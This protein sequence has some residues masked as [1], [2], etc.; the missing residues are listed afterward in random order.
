[1]L[2]EHHDYGDFIAAISNDDKRAAILKVLNQIFESPEFA[3]ELA[4]ELFDSLNDPD[5][6]NTHPRMRQLL[7]ALEL[8]LFEEKEHAQSGKAGGGKRPY[9]FPSLRLGRQK[10]KKSDELLQLSERFTRLSYKCT[11]HV[12]LREFGMFTD[13]QT[14]AAVVATRTKLEDCFRI[15]GSVLKDKISDEQI[16]EWYHQLRVRKLADVKSEVSALLKVD[17]DQIGD[18]YERKYM[19]VIRVPEFRAYVRENLPQ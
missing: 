17:I 9:P 1:M 10:G 7:Q 19:D 4:L 6:A 18:R 3:D 8:I 12:I 13:N 11:V 5:F 14:I 16:I 15:D 2:D